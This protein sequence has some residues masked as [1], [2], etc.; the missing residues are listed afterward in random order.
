[1]VDLFVAVAD[2]LRGVIALL[3]TFLLPTD[4]VTGNVD[5]TLL[6]SQP[7]VLIIWAYLIWASV[8]RVWDFIIGMIIDARYGGDE[9]RYMHDQLLDDV[10]DY[11]DEYDAK[12]SHD[13][14]YRA[15]RD[16]ED[17]DA[18]IRWADRE[19]YR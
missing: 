14:D 8:P 16:E 11:R 19:Y 13:A 18:L 5:W 9:F 4:P 2:F 15:W 12:Y 7:Y 3:N 6:P 10:A 17:T 1:M